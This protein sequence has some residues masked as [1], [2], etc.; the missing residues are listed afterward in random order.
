M[1]LDRVTFPHPSA[2]IAG[3]WALMSALLS[4]AYQNISVP[5]QWSGTTVPQGATIQ[6]GS[7]IYFG[8]SDTT[9]TG[10]PS[11]YVKFTPNVGDSG[12]TCDVAFVADLSGVT[13]NKLYNGYY[14]SGNLIVF[15][16][17]QAMLDADLALTAGNTKYSELWLTAINAGINMYDGATKDKNI[18]FDSDANLLWDES[19]DEFVFDKN[20]KI[21]LQLN[22]NN[23]DLRFMYVQSGIWNMVATGSLIVDIDPALVNRV[24]FM[25][26]TVNHD[27]DVAP[28]QDKYDLNAGGHILLNNDAITNVT[29]VRDSGGVFDS[30]DYNRTDLSRCNLSIIY[31]T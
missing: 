17:V 28:P 29:L 19:E 21:P 2:P 1:A 26:V 12:A 3:D 18:K 23:K 9:I 30:T 10:T 14:S 22:W 8:T 27:E 24:L 31:T 15:D 7:I 13:W 5:I 6:I 4:K 25:F 16:E 11:P 20:L